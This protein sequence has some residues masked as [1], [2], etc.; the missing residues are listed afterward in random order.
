[1]TAVAEALD[2][3]LVALTAAGVDSPRL[4][5]E[6]LLADALGVDRT[7]LYVDRDLRVEGAAVR[8]FQDLVRRRAVGREPVAY[9]LGRKGFRRLELEVDARVL[10]PRPETE[11]LVEVGVAE[12]A[13]GARV[14]DVGTGSG[15]VALALADERRD[16]RVTGSDVSAAALDVARANGA[17]LGL[18]VD[19][20]LGDGLPAGDWDAVVA[21][22]PYVESGER[23]APEIAHHEPALALFA[24]PDG[25]DAIRALVARAA[26]RIGWVA[27]EHGATQGPAVR[28][29]L[30][31]AGYAQVRTEPDLAGHERVTVGC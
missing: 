10:V 31:G 15:A 8:R 5:A 22:L 18:T 23:L 25:L 13:A 28:A 26:H 21:N 7:R 12:L 11:L 14:I 2:S 20:I 1:M 27:L 17:R 29:L 30:G 24:G 16:L 9:L 4:D 6:L 3:A 19:W